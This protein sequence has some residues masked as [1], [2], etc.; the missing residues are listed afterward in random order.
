MENGRLG[1]D[2][3]EGEEHAGQERQDDAPVEEERWTGERS[4][5]NKKIITKREENVINR[6]KNCNHLKPAIVNF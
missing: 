6:N 5:Q 3:G 1:A 2:E 4:D